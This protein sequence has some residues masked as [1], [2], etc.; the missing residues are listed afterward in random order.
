MGLD[1][2]PAFW[3]TRDRDGLRGS[4]GFGPLFQMERAG[5]LDVSVSSETISTGRRWVR[6]RGCL[7]LVSAG[8]GS[9][10]GG[11]ECLVERCGVVVEEGRIGRVVDDEV[12]VELVEHLDDLAHGR[13]EPAQ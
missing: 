11:G 13:H 5:L 9:F 10:E 8:S 1:A 2:D 4:R 3:G 12:L 6:C 7:R